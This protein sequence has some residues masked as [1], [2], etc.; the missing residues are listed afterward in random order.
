VKRKDAWHLAWHLDFGQWGQCQ[1]LFFFLFCFH[2][3]DVAEVVAISHKE[4]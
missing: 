3:G 4:V 2:F 1:G